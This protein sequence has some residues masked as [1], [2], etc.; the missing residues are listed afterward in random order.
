MS[1]TLVLALG[2]SSEPED[3][4]SVITDKGRRQNQQINKQTN[5][6]LKMPGCVKKEQGDMET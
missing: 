6:N 3:K 5:K 2:Y 1:L 4:V